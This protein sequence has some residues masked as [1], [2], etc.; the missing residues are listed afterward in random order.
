MTWNMWSKASFFFK[1]HS[2][3]RILKRCFLGEGYKDISK[4]EKVLST[5]ILMGLGFKVHPTWKSSAPLKVLPIWDKK[6][7][8]KQ[9]IP[10]FDEQSSIVVC[11]LKEPE[12]G[13]F[14]FMRSAL[15]TSSEAFPGVAKQEH[16]GYNT[17]WSTMGLSQLQVIYTQN[18]LQTGPGTKASWE[19]QTLDF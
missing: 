3:N 6:K 15:K 9:K 10:V 5:W 7:Y 11:Y 1:W 2:F 12:V 13:V 14:V 18:S 8:F 16:W 17:W 19:R 4:F